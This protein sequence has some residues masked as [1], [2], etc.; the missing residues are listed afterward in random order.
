MLL[1][2]ILNILDKY[3]ATRNLIKLDICLGEVIEIITLQDCNKFFAMI[4]GIQLDKEELTLLPIIDTHNTIFNNTESGLFFTRAS[5]NYSGQI[6]TALDFGIDVL[7]FIPLNSFNIDW[8][9][10]KL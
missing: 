1:N 2:K 8:N 3:K 6:V 10:R 7:E 9:I 5:F 4:V